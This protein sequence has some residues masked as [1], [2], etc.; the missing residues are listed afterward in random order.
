MLSRVNAGQFRVRDMS[1]GASK[2]PGGS[3]RVGEHVS[4]GP[5]SCIVMMSDIV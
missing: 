2:S 3:R 1:E 5:G 4:P